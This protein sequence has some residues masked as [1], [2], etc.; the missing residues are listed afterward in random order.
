MLF[1]L[2]AL[3][4]LSMFVW[5]FGF[6]QHAGRSL[7]KALVSVSGFERKS[8]DTSVGEI[9]YLEGGSGPTVVFFHG[10]YARKEHWLEMSM[11]LS[12][13]Y[14]VI[15][16]DLPGFGDNPPMGEGEYAFDAQTRNAKVVLDALQLKE[17]HLA[18]NSMG[19]QLVGSI[20][21]D[22]PERVLSV[23]F[24]G[25]PV[26][27]KSPTPSDMETAMENGTAPLVVK[28]VDTFEERMSWLFPRVPYTPGPVVK[29]WRDEEIGRAALNAR[30][31][32]ELNGV[33]PKTWLQELAPEISQ[34]SLILWC[35]KERIFHISGA[36][37]LG[38][39][40]SKSTVVEMKGCGHL[41]MLDRASESGEH[42]GEFLDNLTKG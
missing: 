22:W 21:R 40:I 31:W 41:P 3:M 28:D 14:H 8:I 11:K 2:L 7:T 30:I 42:Y 35:D 23:S 20:A 38:D 5:W 25:G 17:F 13:R 1:G 27:V 18:G 4:V 19:A 29:M 24:I 34:P 26:G 32:N 36:K 10:V 33:R 12:D 6:P 16:L 37:V 39:A 9:Q 15:A